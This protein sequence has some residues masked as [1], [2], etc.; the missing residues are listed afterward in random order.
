MRACW[1]QPSTTLSSVLASRSLGSNTNSASGFA[2]TKSRMVIEPPTP[3]ISAHCRWHVENELLN[4][5]NLGNGATAS[6]APRASA[7]QRKRQRRRTFL[8][9]SAVCRSHQWARRHTLR[10]TEK[11]Q[12]KDASSGLLDHE[13]LR[14][15]RVLA[16]HYCAR[17]CVETASG[18]SQSNAH[19][20][21]RM[22]YLHDHR[23]S[24]ALLQQGA[25]V[26]THQ[27]KS[28]KLPN[29]SNG[30]MRMSLSW[31]EALPGKENT[32]VTLFTPP[33]FCT[34]VR[35]RVSS[36]APH[37]LIGNIN[38]QEGL[39]ASSACCFHTGVRPGGRTRLVAIHTDCDA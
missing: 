18:S 23:V 35:T 24:A 38:V 5:E 36:R 1:M 6:Q 8:R 14:K 29:G 7:A 19:S 13:Q 3:H 26:W 25:G 15:P 16:L 33:S 17:T 30:D 37:V 9:S 4:W 10:G 22:L 34:T 12:D 31:K 39:F 2:I 28:P 20:A 11:Q 32:L 27:P 21:K